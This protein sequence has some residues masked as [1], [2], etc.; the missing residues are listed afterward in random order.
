MTRPSFEPYC[1]RHRLPPSNY[2]GKRTSTLPPTNELRTSS[3]EQSLHRRHHDATRT[4][5]PTSVGRRGLAKKSMLPD[6]PPLAPKEHPAEANVH[7]MTSSTPSAHTIRTCATP[8]ETTETSSTPSGTAGPSNLYHLP[9]HEEDPENLDNLNSRKG[10]ERSILA[11]RRRSQRHLRR[12]WVARKQEAAEAQRPSDTGG[13]HQSSRPI[14]MVRTPDHLHSSGSVAQLRSP[15]QIPAPRRSGDPREQGKEGV[16]GR[17][18]QHQRH[19]PSDTPRLRSR[20][21]KAPRV[22]YSFLRH[23]AD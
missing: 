8:S 10:E 17:G 12:T 18:K 15:R 11:H 16:S 3:E 5:N 13:D 7:W 22:R 6:H 23:C 19:L 9:H 21:Q 4:N 20:T 1:K 2:L 14:S